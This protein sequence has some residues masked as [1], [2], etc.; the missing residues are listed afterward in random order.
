MF[1]DI[2]CDRY[3]NKDECLKNADHVKIFARRFGIETFARRFGPGSEKKKWYFSENSPQGAWDNFAEQKLLKF[4]ESRHPIFRATTPLSMGNFKSTGRGKLSIYF[5]ADQDTHD[6]IYRIILFVNQFS[7]HGAVAA[8]CE[9]FEDDQDGTGE[10]VILMGQSIVFGEVKAETPLHDENPMNEQIIWQQYI[11]PVESFSPENRVSKFCKEAG[12]MRVVEVGQYFVTK[13]VGFFYTISFSGL[14]WKWFPSRWSRFSINPKDGFKEMGGLDLFWKSRPVF[15]ILN[16][17][18]KL[19]P[20]T[21]TI[22]ILGSEFPMEQSNT[23]SIL[24]RILQKFTQ[25][26]KKN[27]FDKQSQTWLQPGQRQKQN[28]NRENLF[29]RQAIALLHK[30]RWIDIEPSTQFCFVRFLEESHQFFLTQAEINF[31]FEIIIHKNIIGLMIDGK[32]VLCGVQTKISVMFC[33]S[34][35]NFLF[36]YSSGNNLDPMLQDN[37]VIGTGIFRNV[38]HVGCT[39]NFHSIVNNGFVFGAQNLS[40]LIQEMKVTETLNILTLSVLRFAR[41]MHSAWK[42][43]QDDSDI[44]IQEAL[45]FYQ[46]RSNAIVLRRNI[47]SSLYF[48]FKD[49]ELERCC[50][51]DDICFVDHHQRSHWNTNKLD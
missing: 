23:W 32:F 29:G 21:K 25:I 11:Q 41:Y 36:P 15:S 49:W 33:Y 48:M 6:T 18:F 14:F 5:A 8:V 3:D 34:G 10:F 9:E 44:S 37:V 42:R 19:S 22:L 51:K 2:F 28:L 30:K 4:A 1:N 46:T 16:K 47:P 39:F 17:K 38:Y 27:K 7:I 12:F 43:H 13:D 20:W 50:M 45:K 31:I 26:H 35:N 40:L 24:F